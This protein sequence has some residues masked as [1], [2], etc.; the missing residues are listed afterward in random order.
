MVKLKRSD[1]PIWKTL[2]MAVGILG[3]LILATHGGAE[4]FGG[5]GGDSAEALGGAW[6][7]R[8]LLGWHRS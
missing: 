3:I 7:L 1:H 8:E 2:H 4:L 6:L 5:G